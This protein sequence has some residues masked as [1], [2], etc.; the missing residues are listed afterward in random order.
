MKDSSAKDEMGMVWHL[1][2]NVWDDDDGPGRAR[3]GL[4]KQSGVEKWIDPEDG[5]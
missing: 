2:F 5:G 3:P 1:K 4:R